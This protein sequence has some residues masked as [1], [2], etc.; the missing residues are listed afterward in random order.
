MATTFVSGQRSTRRGASV[1][2]VNFSLD[3]DALVLLRQY[4]PL[5]K[6]YGHFLLRLL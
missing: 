5:S 1:V 4:A 2:P 6:A 3:K